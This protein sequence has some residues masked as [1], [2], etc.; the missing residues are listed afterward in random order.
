VHTYFHSSLQY[1]SSFPIL[2][3]IR[4]FN[5]NRYVTLPANRW[6][7][8][9]ILYNTTKDIF[10]DLEIKRLSYRHKNSKI[11]YY[12]INY[13]KQI[14]P[15]SYYQAKLANTLHSIKNLNYEE[16]IS[17]V[18]YYNKLG[19]NVELTDEAKKLSDLKIRDGNKT[20]FFDLYEYSRFFNQNLKG[21]FLFGDITHIPE[22]PSITKSR[23]ISDKN[24]NSILL[25]LDKVRHFMFVK[26][27]QSFFSK[28]DML[29]WRGNIFS[30]QPH[31]IEFLKKYFGHPMCDIGK[32]NKNELHPEWQINRM[33]IDVQCNLQ[34]KVD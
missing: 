34:P 16:I 23:P 27:D 22:E 12:G 24:I 28:K 13:F 15:S 33:T 18:N 30:Y 5:N 21:H 19:K 11:L 14:I 29:V 25:K 7:I 26:N 4:F 20:Y 31:R 10:S 3:P 17:R 32:V 9:T 2:N 6:Q 1:I 8:F